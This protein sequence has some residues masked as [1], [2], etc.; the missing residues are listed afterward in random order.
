M[1][2]WGSPYLPVVWSGQL[3]AVFLWTEPGPQ[4]PSGGDFSHPTPALGFRLYEVVADEQTLELEGQQ[5]I[6]EG[7]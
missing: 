5:P 4:R 6:P 7:H 1:L 2:P 3:R